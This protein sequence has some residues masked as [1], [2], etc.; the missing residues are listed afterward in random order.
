MSLLKISHS[1]IE[2]VDYSVG[3]IG[4]RAI[5]KDFLMMMSEVIKEYP[6]YYDDYEKKS[7]SSSWTLYSTMTYQR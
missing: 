7:Q 2:M 5:G 3:D 1:I 4:D 6:Q